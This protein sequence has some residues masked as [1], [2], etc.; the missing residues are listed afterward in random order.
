MAEDT[1]QGTG[2]GPD[3]QAAGSTAN[4]AVASET[5]DI[6]DIDLSASDAP[7]QI[8][9]RFN[10]QLKG[11][12]SNRERVFEQNKKL[13]ERLQPFEDVSPE[14]LGE[15]REFR[16]R[17]EAERQKAEQ[18]KLDA[19]QELK[20]AH[21][22][23]TRETQAQVE[24]VQSEANSQ[25]EQLRKE[26]E[27]LRSNLVDDQLRVALT[28]VGVQKDSLLKGAYRILRDQIAFGEEGQPVYQVD[29]FT[30][31]PLKDGVLKWS[32][33][34]EAKDYITAPVSSGGGASTSGPRRNGVTNPWA[35]DS[36]N[37]TQQGQLL[38]QNPE[39]AKSLAAAAG[40]TLTL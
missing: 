16:D 13:R 31:I 11:L 20:A 9:A 22:K 27:K 25:L 33:S 39:M 24:K 5:I 1:G 10:A 32:Q 7:E 18:A 4:G 36:W 8:T 28:S 6:S 15:L 40:K 3:S 12:K 30:T 2:Q 26:N 23:W 34:D 21:E 37:L 35:K 17:A 38:R 14:E 29:E 19:N